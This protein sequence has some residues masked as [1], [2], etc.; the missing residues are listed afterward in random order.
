MSY[1]NKLQQLCRKYL[2]KLYRKARD[3]GLDKFVER[4][5]AENENGRC[6]ATVEQVNM[7]ASLCG[8]DRIKRE[9][10]PDLLGMSYRKCNE[11]KIF[12]R[13]RKFKDKGIYSKVDNL[14]QVRIIPQCS[15]HII[16]V[17][18]EKE[19]EEATELDDTAY[20]SIDLGL[21]NLAT[22]FDP[23]RNRCFVIN[24]RPLK[25][26][27][28]FFNKR[29]AFLMSLISG[30]GMSRRIGRLTLKRNCKVHDYMHKASR[31]IVNYCKDNH[32][33]NIVIGNNKDWKQNCNMGK[34]NNQNF[35][36]IPFEK[37]ISMIQYK[38]EEV[39]I[40]V[41]VMEERY[42]SKTDH[43]SDEAMCHHENYMGKRIK[44]GLFRSASGKL[45]N[46]DLNGAI[47]ILRKVVG[48]RLWQIADRGVVETPSRIHFM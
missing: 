38:C 26:M 21:D 13:I 14:C 25:S 15:C 24:G 35:V 46:A 47:G 17:V 19:K 8:D 18:Y 1:H 11:Q 41:I 32:I 16:E 22:S 44:R 10:I 20:L 29:R 34:V 40:K 39:G 31:F 42:T 4:T 23:Q 28:Q 33:G 3:I 6:T 9:E 45:I 48:E 5:I 43:Y 37:L 27:N 2:K 30:Q 7:L 36:S 12:K